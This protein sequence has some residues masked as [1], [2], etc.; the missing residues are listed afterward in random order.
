VTIAAGAQEEDEPPL[1]RA[2]KPWLAALL[3]LVTPGLGQLYAGRWRRGLVIFT[4]SFVTNLSAIYSILFAPGRIALVLLALSALP[5]IVAIVDGYLCARAAPAAY[6]VQPFNRWYVYTGLFLVSATILSPVRLC[7]ML[8]GPLSAYTTPSSSMSPALETGDW[9]F[10]GRL[11]SGPI[12]R[13][14]LVIHYPPDRS[15]PFVKRAVGIP[16]DTLQMRDGALYLNGAQT[17]E[18]YVDPA[19]DCGGVEPDS[20]RRNWGPTVVPADSYFMLGDNRDCSFD[21]R[22]YGLIRRERIIGRILFIYFSHDRAG[23]RWN[24]I[25]MAPK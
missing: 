25:G 4:A 24:R 7:K 5:W 14:S 23:V 18:P 11:P 2:R 21:S 1:T 10:G 9:V 22:A 13:G 15:N 20:A 19:S 17:Q 12:A 6:V 3:S 16:G 8:F